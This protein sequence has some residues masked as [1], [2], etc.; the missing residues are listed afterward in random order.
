MGGGSHCRTARQAEQIRGLT[1]T[2]F[3]T[4]IR[5]YL[6]DEDDHFRAEPASTTSLAELLG[7]MKDELPSSAQ[8]FGVDR[9]RKRSAEDR[10]SAGEHCASGGGGEGAEWVWGVRVASPT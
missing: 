5:T 2:L 10:A 7:Q 9:Q 1:K 4:F 6:L 3:P 8:G